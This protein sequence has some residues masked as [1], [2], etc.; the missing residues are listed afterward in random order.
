VRFGHAR[1]QERSAAIVRLIRQHLGRRNLIRPLDLDD[2]IIADQEVAS[3]R[4]GPG[5]VENPCVMEQR[6][7]HGSSPQARELSAQPERPDGD[8]FRNA[9]RRRAKSDHQ[10]ED[11]QD[12]DRRSGGRPQ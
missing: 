4:F 2:P 7:G 5:S 12:A 6:G 11:Q 10:R 8:K 1:H 9:D 3:K